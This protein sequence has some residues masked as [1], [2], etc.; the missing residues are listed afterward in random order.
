MDWRMCCIQIISGLSI[1]WNDW[2]CWKALNYL[3]ICIFNITTSSITA[4]E[5]KEQPCDTQKRGEKWG[6]ALITSDVKSA[7]G[8]QSSRR[9][10]RLAAGCKPALKG[11]LRTERCIKEEPGAPARTWLFHS[12]QLDRSTKQTTGR[13]KRRRER[14]AT[15]LCKDSLCRTKAGGKV[16][17]DLEITVETFLLLVW[18]CWSWAKTD[19]SLPAFFSPLCYLHFE[20]LRPAPLEV[21]VEKEQHAPQEV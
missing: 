2:W 20:L 9:L 14:G 7:S 18:Y 11:F 19:P 16:G 8:L 10:Q 6:K 17:L 13:N 21:A 3:H 5:N 15:S 12:E 4:E 1:I